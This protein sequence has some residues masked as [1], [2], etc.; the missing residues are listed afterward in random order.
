MNGGGLASNA[1]PATSAVYSATNGGWNSATGVFTPT[2]GNPSASVTVG[3]WAHVFTDGSTTPTFIARV[4]AV[5]STTVTLSTTAKSGTA[6][7]TAGTGISINVGGAWAGPSGSACF[8]LGFVSGAMKNATANAVRVNFKNNQT[9]SI[10]ASMTH[11]NSVTYF[12]GYTTTFGDLG[13]AIF[14]GGTTGASYELLQVSGSGV[15]KTFW[16]D[17][18]LQNNGATGS[19]NAMSG[20]QGDRMYMLRCVVNNVRGSGFI[21]G[22]FIECE[23]YACNKSNTSSTGA[24][25]ITNLQ[26]AIRCIAHSNSGSN[27]DGFYCQGNGSRFVG[28]ISANNGG[29]GFN[30]NNVF[31]EIAIGCDAISNGGNGFFFQGGADTV[32]FWENCNAVNNAGYGVSFS[33]ASG[34][35]YGGRIRNFGFF[36]NTSGQ[37]DPTNFAVDAEGTVTY[38]SSPY[39][40]APNGDFRISLAAAKNA[41]VG[42]FTLTDTGYSGRANN[43]GFPDIGAVQHQDAGGS[44]GPIA[45]LKQFNR[46]SPY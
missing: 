38:S 16:I 5:N 18:I 24:F 27:N 1:E 44:S 29:H 37:F 12:Q 19:A 3:D 26:L 36:G 41:G 4:T 17:L 39:V 43:V 21:G 6:P 35:V 11:A 45:Q 33:G 20:F 2:S 23:A 31:G 32:Q 46:G 7:T 30:F 22:N 9:Y 25:N 14:D 13:K 40:D 8:P 10:T 28:C 15:D 42:S 34:T